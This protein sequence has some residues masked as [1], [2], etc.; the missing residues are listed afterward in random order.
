MGKRSR[1][2]NSS[3]TPGKKRRPHPDVD[4]PPRRR[5]NKQPGHGSYDNDRPP[6]IHIISRE[7]AEER[8]WLVGHSD[9]TTC[10]GILGEAV[11]RNA[12]IVYSDEYR[13]YHGL[14]LAHATVNHHQH[15]WAGDDDGDGV[16]EAHCTSCEGAGA[17]VRTFLRVFRGVD[18]A[19]RQ[20]YVATYEALVCLIR[21]SVIRFAPPF[22]DRVSRGLGRQ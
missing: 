4:D 1:E 8:C 9:K 12:I 2:M 7:T 21:G 11:P 13:S 10:Q 15:E 6:I 18:K 19:Y 20:Y 3:R 22:R 5:A 14:D 16:R 17:G